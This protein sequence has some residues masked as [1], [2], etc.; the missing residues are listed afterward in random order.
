MRDPMT[1]AF[2]IC[3]WYRTSKLGNK[4]WKYWVP[5][6]TIWHVD[7]E[8][9]GTDDSCGWFMR[10][11]HGDKA[12]V[13]RIIK[14]FEFDWDR[15]HTSESGEKFSTGYFDDSPAGFPVMSTHGIVLNLFFLAAL[16]HFD[17]GKDKWASS[18]R[19]ATKF[20]QK[21][22]FDILLF[23]ENPTDSLYTGINHTFGYTERDGARKDR[24]EQMAYCIYGW[25][26]R[27]QRPWYKHP[28][29]HFWHWKIQNHFLQQFKRWAFSRCCKC[30]KGFS[31]G[32]A[33]VSDSWH[34]TGPL[35]FRSEEGTYHSDCQHPKSECAVVAQ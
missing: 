12:T 18:R 22:L 13:E 25:I 5:L 14:R 34:G 17:G 3:L 30:G 4:P 21:N 11:H 23:A 15:T 7:P 27:Q 2:Q 24:I 31:W 32:Y 35:W 8:K 19:K 9:D 29:W 1:Q 26:L 6:F 33:P 20:M 10:S 16:E 28:R